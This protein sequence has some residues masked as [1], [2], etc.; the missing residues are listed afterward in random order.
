MEWMTNFIHN[1]QILCGM[2]IGAG[3]AAIIAF[4]IFIYIAAHLS[5]WSK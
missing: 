2:V 1:H 5:N 4:C 3:V